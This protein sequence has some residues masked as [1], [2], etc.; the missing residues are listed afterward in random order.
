MPERLLLNVGD[1]CSIFGSRDKAASILVYDRVAEYLYYGKAETVVFLVE[2]MRDAQDIADAFSLV[3]GIVLTK[4]F[5]TGIRKTPA[6]AA[7]AYSHEGH[8]LIFTHM[9]NSALY[10]TANLVVVPT[11]TKYLL[12]YLDTSVLEKRIFMFGV[13]APTMEETYI[14]VHYHPSAKYV[15]QAQRLK[16]LGLV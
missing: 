5:A 12:G 3:T 14:E 2:S 16:N 15:H 9:T 7:L 10:R 6:P 4:S 13:N 8:T 1:E 11:M